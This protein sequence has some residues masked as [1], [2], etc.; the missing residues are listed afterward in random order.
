[1]LTHHLKNQILWSTFVQIIG[2]GIQ[3]GVTILSLKLVTQALG[4]SEYGLYGKIAEYALFF[5]VAANLGIFGNTVRKMSER[6]KDGELFVNALLLRMGT[7]FLFFGIGLLW[8]FLFIDGKDFLLGVLFFMSVLFLDY[9]TSVCDGMLQANY[10]MGRA[11]IALILG[12]LI[13][14]G[15]IVLLIVLNTAPHAPLFFLGPLAGAVVTAGISFL[16][17]GLNLRFVWKW[18]GELLKLLLFGSIPFGIINIL[19]NLYFRF[20][21]SFFAA[22]TLT[23]EQ[24]AHYNLSLHFAITASLL[25]TFLMFSSLPALKRAIKAHE[26]D[27]VKQVFRKLKHAFLLLGLALV[28]GGALLGPWALTLLSGEEFILPELWFI[29]PLLLLLASFSYF[30]DL[31]LI[32]LFAFEKEIWFLKRECLALGVA[33][34]ILSSLFLISSPLP[35]TLIILTSS[36]AA[37][38]TIV[39]LGLRKIRTLV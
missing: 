13:N 4:P 34:L 30:Y 35:V 39:V 19:N 5:S 10:K 11:T 18:N 29:L 14:L 38:A 6:P 26:R 23:E 2:K 3:L 9:V 1:M 20:L 28:L 16:F 37:E 25:S 33:L 17:V 12:R 15:V 21:P 24:F 36:L 7:A 31:V 22:R 27:T 8:A 32:T